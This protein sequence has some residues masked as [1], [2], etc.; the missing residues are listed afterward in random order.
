MLWHRSRLARPSART[1]VM[2]S[3]SCVRMT[4]FISSGVSSPFTLITRSPTNTASQGRSWFQ[5]STMLFGPT[6]VTTKSSVRVMP[7]DFPRGLMR[8][9]VN[10][11]SLT[12]KKRMSA[13]APAS[14][15][16]FWEMLSFL[17]RPLLSV[18]PL[19][20]SFAPSQPMTLACRSSVLRWKLVAKHLF[21]VLAASGPRRLQP[22]ESSSSRGGSPTAGC[23]NAKVSHTGTMPSSQRKQQLRS[24]DLRF[25]PSFRPSKRLRHAKPCG[26]KSLPLRTRDC[27]GEASP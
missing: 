26:P 11:N 17:R 8:L 25:M 23:L 16:S 4:S 20:R 14:W 19:T 3:S 6:L 9:I 13:F 21:K 24:R 2:S 10:W 18:S 27:R 15:T 7:V 22:K 5:F 12:S 1:K